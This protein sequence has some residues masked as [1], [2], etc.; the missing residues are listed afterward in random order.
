MLKLLMAACVICLAASGSVAQQTKPEQGV[1][2]PKT[3]EIQLVVTQAERAFEQYKQSVNAE[4]N[5]PA[6]NGGESAL[7]KD[8]EG[9]EMAAELI[10]KL[11]SSPLAFHGLGG[12]LLL[13]TLD[14]AS[15]NSALCANAGMSELTQQVISV[16]TKSA[17]Q[18]LTIIQTC[19]DVSLHLYTVSESVHALL[20]R[21]MVAQQKLNQRAMEVA[22]QCTAA[23]KKMTPQK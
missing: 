17:Y 14:D 11:K 2:F 8:R 20:V 16:D 13:S 7:A 19:S 23:I 9:V 12:L 18:T 5:L 10:G 4:A 1:D 21:E 3:E 15:R 22:D 6:G